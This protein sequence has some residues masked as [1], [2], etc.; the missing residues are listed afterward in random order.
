MFEQVRG[1]G[2][3]SGGRAAGK[4][5]GL[6]PSRLAGPNSARCGP[7]LTR[8]GRLL[9]AKVVE[10]A[11]RHGWALTPQTIAGRFESESKLMFQRQVWTRNFTGC[12]R[13]IYHTAYCAGA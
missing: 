6:S 13:R 2:R 12:N 4:V 10:T 11:G 8:Q 3:L 9:Q 1:S 7:R 5:A